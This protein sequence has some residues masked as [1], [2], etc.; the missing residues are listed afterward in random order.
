MGFLADVSPVGLG[1]VFL[2]GLLGSGHCVGMCGPLILA[3]PARHGGA[4]A[5]LAYNLGRIVTYAIVGAI[6]GSLG[7]GLVRYGMGGSLLWTVRIQLVFALL[8]ALLLMLFGLAKLGFV[9][10][11]G[12]LAMANPGRLPGFRRLQRR[13]GRGGGIIAL[14]ALGLLLGLLPCGLSFAAFARALAAGGPVGGAALGL[15]FGLGTLPSLL[16]V[17]GVASRLGAAHRRLSDLIA[18]LLMIGMAITLAFDA[19]RLL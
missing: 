16:L 19:L 4:L 6:L 7:Q 10:E 3:F 17:G 12:L 1:A 11:R 18:G 15:A 14:F 9:A 13:I 5:H 2:L 8:A